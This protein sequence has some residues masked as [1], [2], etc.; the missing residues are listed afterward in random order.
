[1]TKRPFAVFDIDGTLIRWQLYHAIVD[2][3]AKNGHVSQEEHT[4]VREKR[5]AWKQRAHETSFHEYELA[6]ID[7]FDAAA[8]RL[9][10]NDFMAA[11]QHVFEEYRDQ[12]YTYTRDLIRSLKK[13]DYLLFAISASQIEIVELLAR[14]YGFDDWGGSQY[15]YKNKVF[16]G[17]KFVVKGDEKPKLLETLVVKHD[18][19]C[20]GSIA[21]GD[22]DGDIAMLQIAEQ[23]IAFNPNKKLFQHAQAHDWKVVI[24]RKNMVYALESKDGSYIL[25]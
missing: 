7:A 12:T 2:R 15:E 22:S 18:A 8:R 9:Q 3:L 19:A 25:A 13:Q 5:M 20:S 17:K 11:V 1:M 4:A 16:T 23:P 24:E 10:K 21:V 14:Y 6:V